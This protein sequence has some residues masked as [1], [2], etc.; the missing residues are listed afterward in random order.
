MEFWLQLL[1]V[2]LVVDLI[3]VLFVF[4]KRKF[5]KVKLSFTDQREVKKNWN[6]VLNKFKNKDYAHSVLDADKVLHLTMKKRG[7]KGTVGEILK[8]KASIFSDLNSIWSAH[9][10]RNKIAHEMVNVSGREAKNA[11]NNFKKA[12]KDMGVKL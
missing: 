11:L 5:F 8:N 4:I 10:L 2:F 3:L 9:K 6:R 12:I 7:W 1:I